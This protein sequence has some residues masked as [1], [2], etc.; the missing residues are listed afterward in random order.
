VNRKIQLAPHDDLRRKSL[1]D[2]EH[3]GHIVYE[4]STKALGAAPESA[5]SPTAFLLALVK[6]VNYALTQHK[7]VLS[8]LLILR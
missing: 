5:W 1:T 3:A 7:H 8:S 2:V 6:R 4:L